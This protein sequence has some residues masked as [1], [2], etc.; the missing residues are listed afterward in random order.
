MSLGAVADSA[1]ARPTHVQW[2]IPA[3]HGAYDA[4]T[5]LACGCVL[6][7][8]GS[9]SVALLSVD[10]GLADRGGL[11]AHAITVQLLAENQP[12]MAVQVR[13]PT[14]DQ[15][16]PLRESRQSCT[17]A[18]RRVTQAVIWAW[19]APLAPTIGAHTC[20]VVGAG[21]G[22]GGRR[23]RPLHGTV[24]GISLAHAAAGCPDG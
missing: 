2:A 19:K 9:R 13:P 23:T 20:W 17:P 8:E 11:S 24:V 14:L 21:G 3:P 18:D 4:A 22:G 1:T 5:P 12:R 6:A 7:T 15:T 10:A 16:P